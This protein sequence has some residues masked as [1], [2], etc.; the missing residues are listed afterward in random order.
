MKH[1][2]LVQGCEKCLRDVFE[3]VNKGKGGALK[4]SG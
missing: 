1:V 3:T 4:M 2:G